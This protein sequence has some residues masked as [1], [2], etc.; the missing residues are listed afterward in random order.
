MSLLERLEQDMKQA[1]KD[2]DKFRLSVIRMIRSAIKNKE[3][4]E[5]RVPDE[6][7]VLDI[8][9]REVK[10]R[11]DSLQDFEKAGREDLV[12]QVQKE[13]EVIMGYLPKQLSEEEV[14]ALVK[15]TIQDVG[16]SSKAD[17][18][19]VMGALM[20]KIKGRADGKTVNQIVQKHLSSLS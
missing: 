6:G 5:Q 17:M 2:K 7:E 9:N 16:A 20:P 18:G 12:E 10:Q 13:I 15:Q 1:M 11:K 14:E 19:K 8:L 3:I 4:S